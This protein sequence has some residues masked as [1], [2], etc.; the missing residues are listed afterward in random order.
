MYRYSR[1]MYLALRDH[2]IAD[3]EHA[4]T[5]KRAL[6]QRCEAAVER[7]ALDP[8]HLSRPALRLFNNVRALFPVSKQ[9]SVYETISRHVDEAIA[10]LRTEEGAD[11]ATVNLM[12]CRAA[13]RRGK[14][15]QRVPL[16]GSRFCPSHKHLDPALAGSRAA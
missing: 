9:L 14:A 4:P 2:V 6:L 7:I 3:A 13:T 11:A 8:N 1:E 10:F 5:A 16:P 12:R 15:C